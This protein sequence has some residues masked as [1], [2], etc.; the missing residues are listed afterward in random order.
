MAGRQVSAIKIKALRYADVLESAPTLDSLKSA[1]EAADKIDN[2][3]QGTFTYEETEPTVNQYKNDLTNQVYR[4]DMEA[5]DVTIRFTIGQ[6]DFATKA[7]LQGG[8]S[9][10]TQWARGK[11]A[12]H[13]KCFYALT[14]DDVLIVFPKGNVIGT[15]ASTDNAVGIAMQVI[16]QEINSSIASEYWFDVADL[17]I[18]VSA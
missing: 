2:S 16:P 6:Y 12:Q 18:N 15:G 13:Y 10:D 9:T 8:T 5:G 4:S 11:A 1:F 17:N 7:A 3:H 14:E